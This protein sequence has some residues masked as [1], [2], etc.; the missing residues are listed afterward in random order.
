MK[1]SRQLSLVFL[2]LVGASCNGSTGSADGGGTGG[3]SDG[4]GGAG[5]SG[6]GGTGGQGGQGGS[7]GQLGVGGHGS[8]SGGSTGSGGSGGA[9]G[10]GIVLLYCPGETQWTGYTLCA[11]AAD[12]TAGMPNCQSAPYGSTCGT[13]SRPTSPC[14]VDT[15]CTTG[16]CA[17]FTGPCSC[18]GGLLGCAA[19]CT[20]TSCPSDQQCATS[21]HC[22]PRPCTGNWTCDAGF[23]CNAG[24]AGAD[25]HG[26]E[27]V[28]CGGGFACPTGFLCG[29]DAGAS[30]DQHGCSIVHCGQTGGYVCPA[31]ADCSATQTGSGCVTRKCKI[32]SDCQ[33]GTCILGNCAIR[34]DICLPPPPA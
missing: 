11:T 3:A 12:C 26:C 1:A 16:V 27:P 31:N 18:Q 32:S 23:R 6:S 24:A 10:S 20:A 22:V 4:T 33:C 14:A 28:P 2:V 17:P 13:C 34:P 29:A 7:A 15:D 5:A 30:K 8:G 19:A 21:G 9:K 25:V